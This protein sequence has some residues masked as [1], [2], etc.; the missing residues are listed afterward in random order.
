MFLN[1]CIHFQIKSS[2]LNN[3][4]IDKDILS[5]TI[6]IEECGVLEEV[7]AIILGLYKLQEK[8][9]LY[10]QVREDLISSHWFELPSDYSNHISKYMTVV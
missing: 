8:S 6:N 2:F 1:K 7:I 5:K 4:A 10:K 3:T 9:T